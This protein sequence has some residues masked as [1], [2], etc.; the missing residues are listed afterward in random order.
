MFEQLQNK[1]DV[2]PFFLIKKNLTPPPTYVFYQGSMWKTKGR[3]GRYIYSAAY[4]GAYRGGCI[5]IPPFLFTANIYFLMAVPLRPN[6]PLLEL[7]ARQNYFF[8]I[9]VKISGNRF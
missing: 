2:F 6:L 3:R 5:D 1:I 7:K 8:R 4:S 9:N